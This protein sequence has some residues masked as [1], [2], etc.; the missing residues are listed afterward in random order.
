MLTVAQIAIKVATELI[1]AWLV[2]TE[3]SLLMSIVGGADQAVVTH[4]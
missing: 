4:I 1:L 2:M 3:A